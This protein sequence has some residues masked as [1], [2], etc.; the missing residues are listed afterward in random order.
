MRSALS[1]YTLLTQIP[2]DGSTDSGEYC[3]DG[4]PSTAESLEQNLYQFHLDRL[5]AF[6]SDR[7]IWRKIDMIA[8]ETLPRLDEASCIF[9]ALQRLNILLSEK[10]ETHRPPAYMSFVFP[11]SDAQST[12]PQDQEDCL[13]PLP[14]DV[15]PAHIRRTCA[16]IAGELETAAKF[17]SWPLLGVGVNCTKPF[18]IAK[19][20][21]ELRKALP[22]ETSSFS[23]Q[24]GKPVLFVSCAVEQ[25]LE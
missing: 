20:V 2:H 7:Q 9:R 6:T 17:G 8:F 10:R 21:R 25:S 13:L 5:L 22:A 18:R 19:I 15:A 24:T 12:S 11:G 1:F 23:S 3:S 14:S 4:S 16:D